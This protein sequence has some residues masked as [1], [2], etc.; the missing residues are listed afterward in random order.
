VNQP[1]VLCLGEALYDFLADQP[2]LPLE[3]VKSW[4]PYPGGAP[5]NVA[6]GL[7]KLGT[8]TGSLAVLGKMT[9]ALGWWN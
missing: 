9:W 7:A 3:E 5:A 1:R 8:P 6:C 4:T 2:G